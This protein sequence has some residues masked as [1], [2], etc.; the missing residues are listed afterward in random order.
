MVSQSTSTGTQTTTSTWTLD[1]GHSL[2]EFG[3]KHM[4]VS[5]TKGRFSDIAGTIVIDETDAGKSTVDVTIQVASINTFDEKRDAH[6]KSPD[7]F[8]VEHFP[9]ITLRAPRSSPR[10]TVTFA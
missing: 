10:A 6:L 5:T 3:V 4:M 2:A 1:A 8:D 7:F 9:V